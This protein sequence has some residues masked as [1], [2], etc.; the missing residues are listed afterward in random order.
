MRR[1]DDAREAPVK[2]WSG[3]LTQLR[4]EAR[5]DRVYAELELD[6]GA[7]H[8]FE[9]DGPIGPFSAGHRVTVMVHESR[10][11]R[12]ASTKSR[13]LLATASARG[14]GTALPRKRQATALLGAPELVLLDEPT[15]G[16]DPVQALSLRD[17][18]AEMRGRVTLVVSSHNLM[19]LER[20]MPEFNNRG[21]HAIALSS[22]NAERAQAMVEK[23][24]AV[25]LNIGYELSLPSA[26]Q[27]GLYISAS[28][29]QTSIGIEEPALFSEP[30]VFILRPDGTLYYG[31]TQTM[32]FARPQFQ[33]LLG[34][35]DFALAKDYPARGEYTGEV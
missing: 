1:L 34:A 31:S 32:P 10:S 35:I 21:V 22:D 30:G 27:W 7:R 4:Y 13:P 6:G 17:A 14:P 9:A 2:V 28:R 33:D 26:R 23:I 8:L 11:V 18:L 20:L 19:E 25:H 29:G 24:K 15:A 16:L 3:V 5:L 12:G